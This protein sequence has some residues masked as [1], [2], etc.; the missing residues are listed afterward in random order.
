MADNDDEVLTYEADFD[1][2]ASFGAV[3]AV[4]VSNEQQHT[5]MFLVEVK[6]SSSDGADIATIRCN[7]WVQ[8]NSGDGAGKR[9][10]FANKVQ[11]SIMMTVPFSLR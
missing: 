2:P 6:L 11:G 9:V 4:L 5:E 7:S 1:V 3:G 8:P 10:F